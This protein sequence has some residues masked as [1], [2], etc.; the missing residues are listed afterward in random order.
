VSILLWLGTV[1]VWLYRLNDALSKFNPLFIIP[2]LQC[3]FIFFAIVSGGIFFKEF[4]AFNAGQWCGFIAGVLVMFSGLIVLVPDDDLDDT[5]EPLPDVPAGVVALLQDS[6]AAPPPTARAN[7]VVASGAADAPPPVPGPG[8]PEQKEGAAG[9]RRKSL[10]VELGEGVANLIAGGPITAVPT[11]KNVEASTGAVNANN[12]KR[13]QRKTVG[14]ARRLSLAGALMVA[15]VDKQH[16]DAEAAKAKS[17]VR[18]ASAMYKAA[19]E[20]ADGGTIGAEAAA[21]VKGEL[22]GVEQMVLE[23]SPR[24]PHEVNANRRPSA[25][26]LEE[27]RGSATGASEGGVEAG[28]DL[29]H[30][31]S[32]DSDDQL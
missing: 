7:P 2:L 6:G 18:R 11:P 29:P 12:P 24:D 16:R 17:Q 30:A 8:S 26:N 13:P 22:K 23:L 4:I 31:P 20:K 27:G 32:S 28:V 3:N 25:I 21:Q 14:G 15:T 9:G 10:A 19:V 1:S 5:P